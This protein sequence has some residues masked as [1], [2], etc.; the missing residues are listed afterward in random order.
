MILIQV[1]ILNKVINNSCQNLSGDYANRNIIL[2]NAK[3]LIN[4][5]AQVI[6]TRS[7]SKYEI[8]F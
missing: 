4:K 1:Q 3:K 8:S 7:K 6:N 2:I 5:I